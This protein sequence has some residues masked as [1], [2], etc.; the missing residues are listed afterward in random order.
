MR[1]NLGR[2][3]GFKVA[4]EDLILSDEALVGLARGCAKLCRLH[5]VQCFGFKTHS[6]RRALADLKS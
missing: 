4:I 2:F 1:E 5:L 3:Q 6:L